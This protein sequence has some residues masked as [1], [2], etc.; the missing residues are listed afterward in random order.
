M[1]AALFVLFFLNQCKKKKK[2]SPIFT[3]HTNANKTHLPCQ[4]EDMNPWVKSWGS[5]ERKVVYKSPSVRRLLT[6]NWP[7]FCPPPSP[8]LHPATTTNSL[9]L[10]LTLPLSLTPPPT[11]LLCP[12]LKGSLCA[13]VTRSPQ[14][15]K[16]G[17]LVVNFS[18][19]HTQTH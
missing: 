14:P 2:N 5:A 19:P 12:L 6:W 16:C 11:L 1:K 15:I 9:S 7:C 10:S 8:P 17:E 13:L 18:L 4:S 3:T